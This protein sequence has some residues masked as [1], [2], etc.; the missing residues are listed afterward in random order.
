VTRIRCCLCPTGSPTA[1]SKV[2]NSRWRSNSMTKFTAI[3][4]RTAIHPTLSPLLTRGEGSGKVSKAVQ[5]RT[6]IC[7]RRVWPCL[8]TEASSPRHLDKTPRAKLREGMQ[9][10][11]LRALLTVPTS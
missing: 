9:W 11:Q 10:P 1:S 2:N 7:F 6:W 8:R 4:T 5:W 3:P